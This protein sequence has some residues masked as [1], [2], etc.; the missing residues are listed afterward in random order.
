M[1]RMTVVCDSEVIEEADLPYD[2]ALAAAATPNEE[3]RPAEPGR[4]DARLREELPAQGAEAQPV[5]PEA[6][7]RAARASGTRR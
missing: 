2:F 7:R 6:R 3:Q 5:E 1:A 4:G